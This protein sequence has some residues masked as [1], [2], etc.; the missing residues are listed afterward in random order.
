VSVR[1]G[2]ADRHA[3]VDR[4]MTQSACAQAG[5]GRSSCTR[6]MIPAHGRPCGHVARGL[7]IADD[8]PAVAGRG[9]DRASFQLLQA[10]TQVTHVVPPACRRAAPA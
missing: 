5:S 1:P 6:R 10:R 2:H 7:L 4:I 3:G 9:R 8:A